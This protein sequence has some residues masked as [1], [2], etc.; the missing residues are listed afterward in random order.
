MMLIGGLAVLA[1]FAGALTRSTF[2]FGE[3]VVSMPLLALLPLGLHTAASLV[4]LA[5]LTVAALSMLNRS[6]E[7]DWRVLVRLAAGTVAGVP[8]GIA[9][10]RFLPARTVTAA[11]GGV[12]VL[13]GGY[14]LL[15]AVPRIQAGLAWAYPA[16]LAAGALGSAYNFSGVPVVIYGTLRGWHPAVFRGTLQ[17]HFLVAG[18]L[19]VVSQA[20]G[21]IW[22]AAVPWLFAACL[23]A[24]GIATWCGHLLHRRIPA[25]R[26]RRYVYLL[27]L[28]LG[29]VLLSRAAGVLA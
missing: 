24:I 14:G 27:V 16:G 23:P 19:V 29:A 28:A 7:L 8:L 21:G 17:A 18:V 2:G 22:T 10:L 12:L 26:F 20:F 3:A 4:G 6:R 1:V 5:G 11:L 9:L 25:D 15:P 13:Y